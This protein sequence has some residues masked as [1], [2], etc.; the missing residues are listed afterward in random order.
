MPTATIEEPTTLLQQQ[1]RHSRDAHEVV[2]SLRRTDDTSALCRSGA[3][4]ERIILSIYL[5]IDFF[6]ILLWLSLRGLHRV[7][8]CITTTNTQL[9]ICTRVLCIMIPATPM[10]NPNNRPIAFYTEKNGPTVR[11]GPPLEELYN[12]PG[13]GVYFCFPWS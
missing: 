3:V 2:S 10:K 1:A 13:W 12:P 9:T 6:L 7:T 5:F 11:K 8:T 4:N